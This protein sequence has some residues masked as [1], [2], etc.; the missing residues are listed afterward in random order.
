MNNRHVLVILAVLFLV[1]CGGDD[2]GPKYAGLESKGRKAP[3]ATQEGQ[4]L[5]KNLE[6]IKNRKPVAARD[7]APSVPSETKFYRLTEAYEG[8]G[9]LHAALKH[10][11]EEEAVAG[12]TPY[13]KVT[14][15]DKRP[16]VAFIHD[17]FDN[18]TN[19]VQ[20]IWDDKFN[21]TAAE[22]QN[23]G[24]AMLKKFVFC[25]RDE[26]HI[27]IHELNS[28]RIHKA[29]TRRVAI[30]DTKITVTYVDGHNKLGVLPLWPDCAQM[31]PLTDKAKG[32]ESPWGTAKM[33]FLFS[34][35]GELLVAARYNGA[36]SLDS[37]YQGIS[38]RELKWDENGQLIEE[39]IYD[40]TKPSYHVVY[41]REDGRLAARQVLGIDGK[42]QADYLGVAAY[43]YTYNKRG[44]VTTETR[45][46]VAGKVVGSI[47]FTYNRKG[48]VTEEQHLDGDGTVLR[49]FAH[50]Y[51][52]K[53]LRTEYAVYEDEV[54]DGKLI[55]DENRV[56][57]Y[58]WQY[59]KE[60]ELL[61]N[62]HHG[63]DLIDTPEGKDN[64][65]VNDLKG[66][67][68]M[69]WG[70]EKKDKTHREKFEYTS[71][72][73]ANGNVVKEKRFIVFIDT[74]KD[75]ATEEERQETRTE[76]W[77]FRWSYADGKISG[78]TEALMD[79][80]SRPVMIRTMDA[81]QQP[82]GV[83]KNVWGDNGLIAEKAWFDGTGETKI[84]NENGAHKQAWTYNSYGKLA[85]ETW[86]DLADKMVM[87]KTLV[88]D[89]EGKLSKT[90]AIDGEGKPIAL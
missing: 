86:T 10:V 90:T 73:D 17:S 79:R 19:R 71:T 45:T 49:S 72:V 78:G 9:Y 28:F 56:A 52:K 26:N 88:Y 62:S 24:G 15:Y 6:T 39:I 51:Q 47:N 1:N 65:L 59:D 53:G 21:I 70:K 38:K 55:L 14:Y 30:S 23:R 25:P 61:S 40:E 81:A 18:A 22:Y 33:E 67:A 3:E 5:T 87:T 77:I 75:E 57:I 20:Y 89:E 2:T 50:K 36:G 4:D 34:E 27:D 82:T 63:L 11:V 66:V 83:V 35:K 60:G 31:D 44:R 69:T 85:Q 12:K 54:K 64:K 42:P 46:D 8:S 13:V 7:E 16:E 29:Y 74:V 43:G 68:K 58:R 32:Y 84:V 48:Y 37:D 76:T 41:T 80:S